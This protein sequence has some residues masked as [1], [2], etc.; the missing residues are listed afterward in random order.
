MSKTDK[1][2]PYLVQ[3]L[4]PLNRGWVQEEHNH[5]NGIC[6][7]KYRSA[8]AEFHKGHWRAFRFGSHCHWGETITA[9]NS[10]LFA[11]PSKKGWS[12]H[13]GREGVARAK[14][15]AQVHEWRKLK[16]WEDLDEREFEPTQA[17]LWHKW[18]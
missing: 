6:D 1:T 9:Y 2:R 7:L 16:D 18:G 4:D 8:W 10:G 13:R 5:A 15:R 17:R 14:L 11:R 12:R 3:I